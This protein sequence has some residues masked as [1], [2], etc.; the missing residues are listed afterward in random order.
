MGKTG[1]VGIPIGEFV[2][3]PNAGSNEGKSMVNLLA[4]EFIDAVVF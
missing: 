3:T 4:Q 1:M 2:G